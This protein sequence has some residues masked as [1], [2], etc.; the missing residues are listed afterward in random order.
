MGIVI[1][2]NQLPPEKE[3]YLKIVVGFNSTATLQQV[4]DAW[5]LGPGQTGPELFEVQVSGYLNSQYNVPVVNSFKAR[6]KEIIAGRF[7]LYH[8][9]NFTFD[10]FK[11]GTNFSAKDA[12]L[13]AL[14]GVYNAK[15]N[16]PPVQYTNPVF[17]I[18]KS[19]GVVH[20]EPLDVNITVCQMGVDAVIQ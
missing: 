2:G 6:F 13:N 5:L 9:I 18:H 8:K 17:H 7:E 19:W 20:N 10:S 15:L 1:Q 16:P 14:K 3:N 12:T 11:G 4:S